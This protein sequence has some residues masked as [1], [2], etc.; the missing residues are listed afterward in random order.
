MRHPGPPPRR[1]VVPPRRRKLHPLD[2]GQLQDG[3]PST[4]LERR[5]RSGA[6][7]RRIPAAPRLEDGQEE[8]FGY[9]GARFLSGVDFDADALRSRLGRCLHEKHLA[10]G[11][12][13]DAVLTFDDEHLE[14]QLLLQ[15]CWLVEHQSWDEA[16]DALRLAH[17]RGFCELPVI[18]TQQDLEKH[19]SKQAYLREPRVVAQWKMVG[20]NVDL[21]S[22]GGRFELFDHSNG[23]LR[24]FHDAPEYRLDSTPLPPTHPLHPHSDPQDP[25]VRHHIFYDDSITWVVEDESLVTES[26]FSDLLM[27]G[28]LCPRETMAK[29]TYVGEFL[30][31]R[32]GWLVGIMTQSPRLPVEGCTTVI[33]WSQG[34][35]EGDLSGRK[36]L[37]TSFTDPFVAWIDVV[38]SDD[39]DDSVFLDV[40]TSEPPAVGVSDAPF[41]A[42]FRRTAAMARRFLSPIADIVFDG[43]DS[44]NDG[45]GNAGED[46]DNSSNDDDDTGLEDGH[47]HHQQHQQ[48]PESQGEATED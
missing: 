12:P 16:A 29:A 2:T 33:G 19:R 3:N 27:G 9:A 1:R 18:V 4:P 39:N 17:Q 7:R 46:E 42:R 6:R 24:V 48:Q 8:G 41:V 37:L 30:R 36:F 13:L 43:E 38:V 22:Q 47:H 14:D 28:I 21:G 34:G 11:T 32:G 25:P 10:D 45:A 20:Q 26:S 5:L 23:D 31:S 15:S 35:E 40:Y 44:D